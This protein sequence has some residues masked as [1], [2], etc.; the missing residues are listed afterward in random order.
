MGVTVSLRSF[1]TLTVFEENREIGKLKQ[2]FED[3]LQLQQ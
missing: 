3:F 1:A 2:F